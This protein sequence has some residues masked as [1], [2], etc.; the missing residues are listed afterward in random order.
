MPFQFKTKPYAHQLEEFEHSRDLPARALWWEMGVGK[1]KPVIDT[2]AHL[3]LSGKIRS[4][5]VL[6][7]DGVHTNWIT[8]EIPAHMVVDAAT[9]LWETRRKNT[10]QFKEAFAEFL[11][12]DGFSV[13]AMTYDAIMTDDAAKAVR[14]FLD[15]RPCLYVLDESTRIKTAKAKVTMRVLA[16]A[17]YAPYRR[18]LNGT[19]VSDSPFHSYT[20]CKFVDPNAWAALGINNYS[21][22]KA[23]FG[24]W[25]NR[26]RKDTKRTWPHL[27]SYRALELMHEVVDSMG[28]RLLKEDVLDLPPKSYTKR[29]YD[30]SSDQRRM[31][32]ELR[33]DYQAWFGDGSAITA[34]LAIV[35][36][37]RLQQVCS[38]YIPADEESE[39]RMICGTQPRLKLLMD[40]LADIPHACIIWA[41]YNI[42][43]DIIQEALTVAG[44]THVVYD[45]RTAQDA[46]AARKQIFQNGKAKVFLAKPSVAGRGLTL[47]AAQTV[48]YYNN[49]FVLDDR[50]QSEDRAHR[51]GQEHPVT[52]IDLVASNTIDQHILNVLRT[53]R[54]V[55]ACV[56]GDELPPW[57]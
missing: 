23:F 42:D 13:L 39:L 56:T 46:R 18:V 17:K 50:L 2:A 3:Y 57:I 33:A 28:S 11:K 20:Q 32:D 6:A 21:Q 53:K 26:I 52:Y 38:G 7:P 51:I 5:L 49:S 54:D 45:G 35:R 30:L 36:Q 9:F 40:T 44:I 29:Y 4:M 34:E 48:I 12:H 19:P 24:I 8:D 47:T 41:K 25:E 22:F 14:K 55:A 10:K 1:T 37:T 15:T 31:Y 43:V 16:S 27:M